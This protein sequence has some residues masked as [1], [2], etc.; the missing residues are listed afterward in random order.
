MPDDSPPP[1]WRERVEAVGGTR[2]DLVV[3]AGAVAAIVF[4]GLALWTRGTPPRIAPPAVASTGGAGG[5]PSP[6]AAVFVHVA[7][8]VR[9]P[10]VF[11]LSLGARVAD[12]IELAGGPLQHAD[13]DAL[14]LAAPVVDGAQILVPLQGQASHRSVPS[15]QPSGIA[16]VNINTADQALLET[17]PGIGP[18]TAAAILEHRSSIGSFSSLDEL[19]DVTGIGPATLESMRAYVTL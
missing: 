6:A 18:V 7:G 4:S 14:N 9:R 13:L 2:R 11:S 3:V 15:S 19:L 12:A 10:G 17:I 1:S 16:T 8:A 5:S